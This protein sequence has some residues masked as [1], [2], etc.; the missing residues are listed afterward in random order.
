MNFADRVTDECDAASRN[1]AIRLR[2]SVAESYL[3]YTPLDW[4]I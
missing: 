2:Q 4:N 3:T 1:L